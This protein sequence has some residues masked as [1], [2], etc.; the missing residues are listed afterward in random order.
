M[1]ARILLALAV[2]VAMLSGCKSDGGS[3]ESTQAP[4]TPGVMQ[5]PMAYKPKGKV[6]VPMM[7]VLPGL[8]LYVAEPIDK[9]DTG[10]RIG[11]IHDDGRTVTAVGV[12]DSPTAV[13]RSAF[14]TE[15][16]R[17]GLTLVADASQANRT[18]TVTLQRFYCTAQGNTFKAFAEGLV[19]VRDA[20]GAVVFSG[21]VTADGG[22]WGNNENPANVREPLCDAAQEMVERCLKSEAFINALKVN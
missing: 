8:R 1:K 9:R 21:F 15:L 20:G 6:N 13:V 4:S 16:P 18:L 5:V 14:T 12:G 10:E 7:P 3:S 17:F 19:E 2:S 22:N 11:E